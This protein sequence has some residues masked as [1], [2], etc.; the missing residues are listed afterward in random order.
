ML[1]VVMARDT[2]KDGAL[3]DVKELSGVMVYGPPEEA[4]TQ[5]RTLALC[6]LAHM[7]EHSAT[8]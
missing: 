5:F 3:P 1:A 8:T 7:M 4:L 2:P 6:V